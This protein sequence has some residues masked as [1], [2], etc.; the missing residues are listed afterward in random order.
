MQESL[1]AMN[2]QVCPLPW[3]APRPPPCKARI[4]A[5][6]RNRCHLHAF[7]KGRIEVWAGDAILECARRSSLAIAPVA[8]DNAQ[9]PVSNAP[10]VATAVDAAVEIEAALLMKAD[11][12]AADS[13]SVLI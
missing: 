11:A 8:D 2:V 6:R 1:R 10:V 12:A 4:L 7:R 3:H 13:G 5:G 9:A